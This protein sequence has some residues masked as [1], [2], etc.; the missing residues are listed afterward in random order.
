MLGTYAIAK[1]A[2]LGRAVNL[3]VDGDP[4]RAWSRLDKTKSSVVVVNETVLP[5]GFVGRIRSG[6]L[7][8]GRSAGTGLH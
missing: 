2:V 4:R 8:T 6:T 1:R 3:F 7:Q 5:D